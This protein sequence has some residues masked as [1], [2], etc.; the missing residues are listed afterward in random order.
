MSEEYEISLTKWK[1]ER[2]A[3]PHERPDGIP[4][5]NDVNW[6]TTAEVKEFYR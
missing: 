4:T 1:A 5:R 3:R 2:G 6:Y